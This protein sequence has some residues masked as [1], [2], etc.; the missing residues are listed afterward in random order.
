[1]AKR[2]REGTP[3][4]MLHQGVHIGAPHYLSGL[5]LAPEVRKRLRLV[6]AKILRGDSAGGPWGVPHLQG[7]RV[8]AVQQDVPFTFL[9][10]LHR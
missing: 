6:M 7:E 8:D 1:M 2:G 3:F 5:G 9:S 10:P 4:F